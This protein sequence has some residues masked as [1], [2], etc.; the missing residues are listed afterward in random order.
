MDY[1]SPFEIV[2]DLG[3][4]FIEKG[5]QEFF[6]KHS[7]LHARSTPFHPQTNGMVER[8]HSMLKSSIATLVG[9]R[10]NRW[11]DVLPQALFAIRVRKH[12]V[13]GYS[14]F[15]LLY[16]ITPRLPADLDLPLGHLAPLDEIE[17]I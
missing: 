4:G 14:P 11:D 5:V 12:A 17:A 1:G 9:G 8:M 3:A 7:I 2:S 13:T 10:T 16:G 6:Q 15:Y